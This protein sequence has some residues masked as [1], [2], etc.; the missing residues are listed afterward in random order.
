MNRRPP[1]STRTDTLFPYTTLF[2]SD[3]VHAQEIVK[4]INLVV[5]IPLYW[6]A[7]AT[8]G[9]EGIFL[10]QDIR[11]GCIGNPIREPGW[12]GILTASSHRKRIR[13]GNCTFSFDFFYD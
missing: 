5:L 6:K 3:G 2:R 12:L 10:Q 8:L 1:R 13:E 7:H 9:I 4:I 11:L